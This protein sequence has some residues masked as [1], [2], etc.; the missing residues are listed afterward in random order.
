MA[1]TSKTNAKPKLGHAATLF[2]DAPSASVSGSAY[3]AE[4]SSPKTKWFAGLAVMLLAIG[5]F[6]L[7]ATDM[8]PY[9]VAETTAPPEPA[10]KID[11]VLDDNGNSQLVGTLIHTNEERQLGHNLIAQPTHLAPL[12]K[13]E[14]ER[15]LQIISH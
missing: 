13:Q 3:L 15:L 1:P 4:K 9:A 12:N 14:R 7:Q 6:A 5:F 2:S 8:H 11:V 10:A